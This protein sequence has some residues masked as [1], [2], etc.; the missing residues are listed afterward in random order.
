MTTDSPIRAGAVFAR[1]A[2]TDPEFRRAADHAK[3]YGRVIGAVA[4]H[5]GPVPTR[6][7]IHRAIADACPSLQ[8]VGKTG[9]AAVAAQL[10]HH[11]E[12]PTR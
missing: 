1:L 8:L 9:I 11:H 4:R 10:S 3:L 2:R 7:G 6:G 5:V 12:E